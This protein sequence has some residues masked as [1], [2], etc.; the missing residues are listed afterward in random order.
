MV[1]L[2]IKCLE[3]DR[4]EAI[5][6]DLPNHMDALVKITNVTTIGHQISGEVQEVIYCMN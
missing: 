2:K 6:K 3:M 5:K 1:S 4:R